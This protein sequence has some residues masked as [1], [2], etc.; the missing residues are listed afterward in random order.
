MSTN[1]PLSNWDA[2]KQI[3]GEPVIVTELRAVIE[4]QAA[5]YGQLQAD[6]EAAREEIADL[7]QPALAGQML[8][9]IAAGLIEVSQGKDQGRIRFQSNGSVVVTDKCTVDPE[10]GR[11]EIIWEPIVQQGGQQ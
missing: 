9:K 7:K 4:Q 5:L 3:P 11:A 6:Y 8:I 1:K 10:R 2:F